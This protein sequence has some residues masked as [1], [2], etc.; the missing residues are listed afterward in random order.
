MCIYFNC[1][2]DFGYFVVVYYFQSFYS[3]WGLFW[4][5]LFVCL[6]VYKFIVTMS[7]RRP[8]KKQTNQNSVHKNLQ[9]S[10]PIGQEVPSKFR[11]LSGLENI[12]EQ[13]LYTKPQSVAY[14]CF[15]VTFL[16][17]LFATY[18]PFIREYSISKENFLNIYFVKYGWGWTLVVVTPYVLIS[19]AIYTLL[20]PFLMGKHLGRLVVSSAMWYFFTQ[21]FDLLQEMNGICSDSAAIGSKKDCLL[22]KGV[23]K[24]FDVSGHCFLLTFCL[25]V[26]VE[27]FKT[28]KYVYWDGVASAFK[29][30]NN[31]YL[32]YEKTQ[33]LI[34]L[35]KLF[36]LLLLF[37]WQWM[38][39]TSSLFFHTFSE[40]L[41]G[42]TCG[43]V[44]WLSTYVLCFHQQKY[45]TYPGDGELGGHFKEFSDI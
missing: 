7:R 2:K 32:F 43:I 16:L 8:I 22:G 31:I 34:L 21:L 12:L 35:L 26:I 44:A 24:G 1:Y 36:A 42:T 4:F 29:K 19:S 3:I 17:S 20:N 15:S 13:T 14:F 39:I 23:W 37:I 5:L 45:L 40:K 10:N 30:E 28:S 18:F 9:P 27:E 38:L 11:I 6:F 41:S 25:L 33:V